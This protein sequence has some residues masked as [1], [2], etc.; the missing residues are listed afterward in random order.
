MYLLKHP[1]SIK[2]K[3]LYS[4]IS[5]CHLHLPGTHPFN[6]NL[7]PRSIPTHHPNT[8]K[9][10]P[11]LFSPNLYSSYHGFMLVGEEMGSDGDELL[12]SMGAWDEGE[13]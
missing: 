13:G 3:P 7:K 10:N 6:R 4:P 9:A 8:T 2:P 12:D 1:N 5:P 11:S